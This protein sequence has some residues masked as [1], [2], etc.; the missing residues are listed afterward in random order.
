M[1]TQEYSNK[2][3]TQKKINFKFLY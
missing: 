2:T 3:F 1:L